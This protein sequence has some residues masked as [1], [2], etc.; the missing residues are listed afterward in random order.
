MSIIYEPKGRALEYAPLA[1]NLFHGCPH[2]CTY[3]Y[4]PSMP[5]W[6][7][8]K[9]R[10]EFHADC[11]PRKDILTK[12]QRECVKMKG[13]PRPI[14]LCYTCDPYPM[15][16][17]DL[18]IY[19]DSALDIMVA[20]DLK[21]VILTKG[22]GGISTMSVLHMT[23]SFAWFGQTISMLDD[24]IRKKWEPNASP[25]ADRI[26]VACEM[27][28]AGVKTWVSV[29]PVVDAESCLDMLRGFMRSYPDTIDHWKIGKL[30]G[31]DKETKDLEASIDWPEFRRMAIFL[32]D[33]A[34]YTR[35]YDQGAFV[36]RTYYIKQ[37]LV[38]A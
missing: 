16:N 6:G 36:P 37:D 22:A 12:L 2:A 5:F 9:R 1:A 20:N 13:D 8:D 10:E 17:R 38:E 14:L 3:C 31:R 7:Y 25:I 18:H 27:H 33:D 32:L 29:E 28:H 23:A 26:Q 19:T 21:P 11:I 30:N 15:Q 34:G 24:D 35:S 4:V